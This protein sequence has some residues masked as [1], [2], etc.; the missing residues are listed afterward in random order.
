MCPVADAN[1][2]GRCSVGSVRARLASAGWCAGIGGTCAVYLLSYLRHGA[3]SNVPT[4]LAF[5][6]GAVPCIPRALATG[7]PAAVLLNPAYPSRL[8][9]AGSK[10][11]AFPSAV[12]VQ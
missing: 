10:P 7:I 9:L 3:D 5:V 2:V 12:V 11:S 8:L 1:A 4:L 6:L